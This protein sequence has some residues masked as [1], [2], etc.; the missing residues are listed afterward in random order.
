LLKLS[1]Q[2]IQIAEVCLGQRR[3]YE[4]GN[5]SRFDL[6]KRAFHAV[7]QSRRTSPSESNEST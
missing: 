7:E 5:G 3:V 1:D 6:A 2:P 4:S